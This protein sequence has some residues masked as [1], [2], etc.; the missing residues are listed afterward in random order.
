MTEAPRYRV[1]KS[2]EMTGFTSVELFAGAGGTALGFEN[3]G[4]NHILLNEFDGAACATLQANRPNWYLDPRDIREVDFRYLRHKV[5]VVV[6]GFP[7]QTFSAAGQRRGFDDPR[8]LL[9]FELV[10]A[11]TEI[12]PRLVIGENVKGLVN[13]DGGRTL[14]IMVMALKKMGYRVAWRVIKAQYY[15]V[16]QKRER[17]IIVGLH[18]SVPGP[19]LFPKAKD[20][21]VTLREAL[22]DVPASPGEQYPP[23]K[24]KALELVPPGGNWRDLP[25]GVRQEYVGKFTGGATA[26]ARRLSWDEPAPTLLTKPQAKLTER[27]HPEETRPLTVREYARV[28]TFPDDW[29]FCGARGNQYKQIGNAVPVNLGYHIGRAAIAMLDGKRPDNMEAAREV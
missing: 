1:L 2:E 20:Y 23:S 10:R 14:R 21:T 5:D 29:Q 4:F 15:D 17:L 13:H 22:Q 16:P 9:F 19:L 12:Q 11:V 24:V 27:C 25:D 6:G 8:G 7:C 28:Q 18:K 26:M 3:A